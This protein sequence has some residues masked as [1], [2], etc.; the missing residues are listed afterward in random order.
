MKVFYGII[1]GKWIVTPEWVEVSYQAMQNKIK[2]EKRRLSAPVKKE[3]PEQQQ[4]ERN[5]IAGILPE[6]S[7]TDTQS[8]LP[9]N[10]FGF[11]MRD[12]FLE[13][14]SI[15][16]TKSFMQSTAEKV[17]ETFDALRTI[18]EF[19]T[20][21]LY[22]ENDEEKKYGDNIKQFQSSFSIFSQSQT[23]KISQYFKQNTKINC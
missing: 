6:N 14:K 4:K 7:K 18:S 21:E 17:P 22:V 1:K 8:F 2:Q 3:E 12:N 19:S 10:D 5:S 15:F 9:E 13:G 16:V 11:R 23:L 20:S